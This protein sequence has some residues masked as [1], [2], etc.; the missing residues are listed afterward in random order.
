ML[1]FRMEVPGEG[2]WNTRE[3]VKKENLK[4]IE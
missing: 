2:M 3:E 4:E 1:K